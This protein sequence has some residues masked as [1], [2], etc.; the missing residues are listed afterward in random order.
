MAYRVLLALL[1]CCILTM[2]YF[3]SLYL[4]YLIVF[5]LYFN[6]YTSCRCFDV[7]NFRY[8]I[9]HIITVAV[10]LSFFFICPRFVFSRVRW[11]IFRLWRDSFTSSRLFTSIPLHSG[12][13]ATYHHGLS[14]GDLQEKCHFSPSLVR[15]LPGRLPQDLGL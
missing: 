13:R 8:E 1:G 2:I 12:P 6:K 15:E 14:T 4:P 5:F 10:E 7:V 11:D 3:Q 9:D